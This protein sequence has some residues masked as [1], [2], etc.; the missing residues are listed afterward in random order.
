MKVMTNNS[1]NS[2]KSW[3][4]ACVFFYTLKFFG[5]APYR[6]N[7]RTLSFEMGFF[8]YSILLAS[9]LATVYISRTTIDNFDDK[10]YESG[11]QSRFVDNLWR[12]QNLFQSLMISSTILFNFHKRKHIENFIKL[13]SK[14]DQ[15]LEKLNWKHKS[16]VFKFLNMINVFLNTLFVFLLVVYIIIGTVLSKN[17]EMSEKT[18]TI[19]KLITY[20]LT[21][22]FYVMV[23]LQFILSAYC[24]YARIKVLLHN[25][26]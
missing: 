16:E 21:C 2:L 8:N 26:R 14:F 9:L 10:S 20:E 15:I 5:L 17:D 23:S 4:R 25:I 18:W 11:V 7:S 19:F 22:Q 1:Q 12:Y 6:F 3:N 24:V 13:I